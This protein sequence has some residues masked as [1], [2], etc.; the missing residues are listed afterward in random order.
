MATILILAVVL[1][2]AWRVCRY[3]LVKVAFAVAL[4]VV[5]N[6]FHPLSSVWKLGTRTFLSIIQQIPG[7][8]PPIDGPKSPCPPLGPPPT[9]KVGAPSGFGIAIPGPDGEWGGVGILI[10]GVGEDINWFVPPP[11][12]G[13]D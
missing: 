7:P 13:G 11:C 5:F 8:F 6:S 2:L 1:L 9:W 3:L 4:F 12:G 10:I